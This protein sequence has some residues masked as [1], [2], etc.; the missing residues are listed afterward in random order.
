MK[1]ELYNK[2]QE[3]SGLIPNNINVIDEAIDIDL[4]M[5]YF[6]RSKSLK[7]SNIKNPVTFDDVC[8]LYD[9]SLTT[10]QL[11]DRLILLSGIDDPKAYRILEEYAGNK[12]NALHQWALMAFHE[13][14]MLLEGSLLNEQQVFVSTGLGG[15][16]NMLRYFV[17]FMGKNAEG[18]APYQ[19]S[20]ISSELETATRNN[21]S[22]LEN[23]EF[24][25]QFVLMKLL[26]PL[27][28]AFHKV[29]AS[30]VKE[31]NQYGDFLHKDFL[32][33]NVREFTVDDLRKF[34]EDNAFGNNGEPDIDIV[35]KGCLPDINL[36]DIDF[37]NLFGSGG[38]GLFD[39]DEDDDDDE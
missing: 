10:E 3:L 28:V 27:D 7:E 14:K 38:G 13:N 24:R 32:V 17:A 30:V 4:Q 15:R 36:D 22:E 23:I 39:D 11:K 1:E 19:Q 18:F 26:F 33:T 2:L 29:L 37:E 25:E 31:C 12:Q 34:V 5:K 21:K 6:D 9:E 16:N 8:N 35:G 20:M